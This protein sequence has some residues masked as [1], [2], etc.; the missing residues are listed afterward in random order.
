MP[1]AL[2][3]R[4]ALSAWLTGAAGLALG[5]AGAAVAANPD[6]A[7]GLASLV[8][9]ELDAAFVYRTAASGGDGA[10]LAGQEAEHA[11]ALSSHLQAL[12]LPPPAPRRSR[13]GLAPE[14]LRVLE[15]GG[16]RQRARAAAAYER[17]LIARCAAQLGRLQEPNILRTVATIM[18]SHAQHLALHERAAELE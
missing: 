2:S 4:A 11:R 1:E 5:V 14:A 15:A 18:A 8:R 6:Q 3:R 10:A 16:V 12:G 7:S 17:T 13:S 9:S